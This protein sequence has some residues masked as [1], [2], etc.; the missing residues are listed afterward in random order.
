MRSR[1]SASLPTRERPNGAPARVSAAADGRRVRGLEAEQERVVGLA[2][3]QADGAGRGGDAA[4][5]QRAGQAERVEH[6][7]GARADERREHARAVGGAVGD[8][9]AGDDGGAEHVAPARQRARR[10]DEDGVVRGDAAAPDVRGP[11][12]AAGLRGGSAEHARQ[13]VVDPRRGAGHVD[14]RQVAAVD[15]AGRLAAHGHLGGDGPVVRDDAHA[16]ALPEDGTVG[17][18]GTGQVELDRHTRQ[19]KRGGAPRRLP[20]GGDSLP[21]WEGRAG[22]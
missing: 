1:S 20:E 3:E 17:G 2:D 18:R 10:S 13:G 9:V 8:A 7:R 4:G 15:E 21:G 14:A 12:G 22:A 19:R 6:A 11:G 16:V 5:R